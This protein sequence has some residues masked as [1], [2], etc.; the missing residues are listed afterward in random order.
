MASPSVAGQSDSAAVPTGTVWYEFISTDRSAMPVV[1]PQH[2][3]ELQAA[4]GEG[5]RLVWAP[6]QG[7]DGWTPMREVLSSRAASTIDEQALADASDP[8][9]A[10]SLPSGNRMVIGTPFNVCKW[11][12]QF[13][14][15]LEACECQRVNGYDIPTILVMLWTTLKQ[16]GGLREEGIFRLAPDAHKCEALRESLNNDASALEKVGAET[17]PHV[18]ANLIKIWFRMLP[19]RLLASLTAQQISE[20]QTGAEAMALLQGLEQQQ[21]GLFLWLLEMMAVIAEHKE[22]NRMNERALAVVVVP[23]LYD[24]NCDV[25]NGADPMAAL[26]F[27]QGMAKF[28]SELLFHYISV[29]RR[30]RTASVAATAATAAAATTSA[31]ASTTNAAASAPSNPE[32]S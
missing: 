27:S 25:D 9:T 6:G 11:R 12:P 24:V 8:P 10:S 4:G 30:V 19:S 3:E 1:L 16:N 14:L 32:A 2:S 22:D 26:T 13:G 15:P 18:L 28:V 7:L 17:D 29:R 21:Q 20:C 23:N 31:A 5:D